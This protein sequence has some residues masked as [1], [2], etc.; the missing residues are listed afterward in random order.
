MYILRALR[1]V[2]VGNSQI[3]LTRKRGIPTKLRGSYG[4]YLINER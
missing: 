1:N 4:V 3:T 2:H